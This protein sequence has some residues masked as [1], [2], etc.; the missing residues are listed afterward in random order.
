VWQRIGGGKAAMAV[1]RRRRRR[2][3]CGNRGGSGQRGG[4]GQ[5]SGGGDGVSAAAASK[6]GVGDIFLDMMCL[7]YFS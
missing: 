1:R 4:Y 3:R 2:R 7:F 5:R 6:C